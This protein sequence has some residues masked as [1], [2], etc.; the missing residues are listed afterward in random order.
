MKNIIY[1]SAALLVLTMYSCKKDNIES[2]PYT[3]TAYEL[4]VPD[5]FPPP[6]L[7]NENPLTVEG[8]RLGRM[9]YYDPILS[10]NGLSC[11]SCHEPSKSFSTG[12]YTA[13]SG[14]KISV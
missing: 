13:P 4:T 2:T 9:L 1:L 12:I 6:Y 10:T 8:V 5:H 7:S 3:P 11:T 14:E